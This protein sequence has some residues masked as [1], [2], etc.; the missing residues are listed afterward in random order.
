MHRLML[1]SL[2]A[3]I[4][5]APASAPVRLLAPPPPIRVL[6]EVD[7]LGRTVLIA[8]VTGAVD[9]PFHPEGEIKAGEV[10]ARNV[11]ATLDASLAAARAALAYARAA[12]AHT[13]QLVAARLSTA[14][15]LDQA[16]RNVAEARNRLDGL[17]RQAAQQ[18][19][20][21]PISGTLHYRIVPGTVVYRG[22]VIATISGR[23]TPWIDLRVTPAQARAIPAGG[24]AR[25][26]GGGWRGTGR[27]LSVG[28]D[29]RPYGLVRVRLGLPAD[30]PLLPGEW[31]RVTL[32]TVGPPALA[33]PRAALLR[34]ADRLMVFVL[35]AGRA[36]AVPVRLLAT[37]A[38]TAWVAGAL[39]P[40][41][42]VAI[43]HVTRLADAAR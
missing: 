42:A 6:G 12:A 9:G 41:E 18:V 40:G 11:P 14:L 1:L 16:R 2:L 10:V 34:R 30:N 24:T 32:G 19:I 13:S 8:P 39:R 3:L 22:G 37:S 7:S 31:V 5:A 4:A 25:I 33:V 38:S 21:A 20:R 36:R 35:R 28:R 26:R 43:A 17:Q 23:A 27:V 15:A 29:A